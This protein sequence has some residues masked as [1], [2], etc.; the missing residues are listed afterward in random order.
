[1][2]MPGGGGLEHCHQI[3]LN[4]L[5]FTGV[6]GFVNSHSGLQMAEMG[7]FLWYVFRL[8]SR[9]KQVMIFTLKKF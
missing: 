1:M 6:H 4:L 2:N 8:F 7:E 9:D 3:P 5:G